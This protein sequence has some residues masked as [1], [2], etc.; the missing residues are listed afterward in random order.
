MF[1]SKPDYFK[2]GKDEPERIKRKDWW[3][4]LSIWR[5]EDIHAGGKP[6]Y[7]CEFDDCYFENEDGCIS[8]SVND[9]TEMKDF[10]GEYVTGVCL[11]NYEMEDMNWGRKDENV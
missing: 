3:Y 7:D 9:V 6:D 1:L 8:A 4:V 5:H 11:S 10:K 2:G